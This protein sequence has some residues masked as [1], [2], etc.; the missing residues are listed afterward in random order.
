MMDTEVQLDRYY[1]GF[2]VHPHIVVLVHVVVLFF[3]VW[4]ILAEYLIK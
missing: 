2:S 1:L 3:L 4:Y